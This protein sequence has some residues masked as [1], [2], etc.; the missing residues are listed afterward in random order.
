MAK[1]EPAGAEVDVAEEDTGGGEAMSRDSKVGNHWE[2]SEWA[3]SRRF[4]HPASLPVI[5]RHTHT[6][7]QNSQDIA[8]K[9]QEI[10]KKL[11][12]KRTK[13]NR[14]LNLTKKLVYIFGFSPSSMM[15]NT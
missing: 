11:G 2:S 1:S 13:Q 5:S 6:H 10:K 15:V 8:E 7:T 12:G 4:Y 9:F 14:D 3:A